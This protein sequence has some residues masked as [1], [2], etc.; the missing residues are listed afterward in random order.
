M[1][2]SERERI[3][4]V[5]RRLGFG[6]QPDLVDRASD[7]DDAIAI[8]FHL[9]VAGLDPPKF[10]PPSAE[11]DRDEGDGALRFFIETLLRGPR[12]LEERLT[13]FWHDHFATDARKVRIPFL[14]FTQDLTLRRHATGSFADLLY[15]VA[16]DPAM[17][18]YL[19]GRENSVETPNE[20][21]GREVMELYTLGRSNYTENDVLAASRAFSGWVV[22]PPEAWA[23]Q[24][25][26]AEP[27]SAVFV[28][29][30][31]DARSKT[32]LGVSGN[33]DAKAAVDILLEHSATPAHVARKLHI[34]L[35]GLAPDT[36]TL[37]RVA[38]AFRRDYRILDLTEA[39]VAEPDFLSDAAIRSKKRTPLEQAIGMFQAFGLREGIG[40]G[41]A[42]FLE[43]TGY[44]PFRPPNP[45][46]YPKGAWLLGPY[47]LVHTFD[48]VGALG[49][50]IPPLNVDEA[51]QR[52]GLFDLS[53]ETRTVLEGV[54]QPVKRLALL[55]NSPEYH[56]V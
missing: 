4:H 50:R 12:R 49:D 52:L 3:S 16:T 26:D 45:A 40:P 21:F 53:A 9:T 13:W 55:L 51:A 38:A 44:L 19:D 56:L 41:F 46:G 1:K 36:A 2:Y 34:D 32:L 30:R 25:L 35:V 20:N 39:I 43:L 27:W 47:A 10:D 11:R 31:H 54:S 8:A 5:M 7:A 6:T 48:L 42:R 18:V 14:V 22:V 17:L 15:A 37:K 24:I 29:F 23:R 33:H 28:G